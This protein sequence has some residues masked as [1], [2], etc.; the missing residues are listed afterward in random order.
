[1]KYKF[2]VG[3]L[4]E[5]NG[6]LGLVTGLAPGPDPSNF[7]GGRPDDARYTV[8]IQ[9]VTCNLPGDTLTKVSESN[10]V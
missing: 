10:D 9:G 7:S 6:S 5:A 8:L 2:K 4:V 1:M 3:E